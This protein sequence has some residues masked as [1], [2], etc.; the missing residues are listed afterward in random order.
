MFMLRSAASMVNALHIGLTRAAVHTL[1]L[2]ALGFFVTL[3]GKRFFTHW[4]YYRAVITVRTR[5][6]MDIIMIAPP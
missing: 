3:A 6:H 1:N 5:S 4:P 2:K